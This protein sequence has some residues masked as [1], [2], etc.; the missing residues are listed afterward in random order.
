MQQSKIYK[1]IVTILIITSLWVTPVYAASGNT[2][3]AGKG[4]APLGIA[5]AIAYV[6]RRMS[7]G[8]WL[9]FYYFQL[10][11]SLILS[12]L[13]G[14][15]IIENLNPA[16]WEDRA[17]YTLFVISTIPAMLVKIVEVLFATRLLFKSQRNLKNV[18]SLRYVLLASVV[19]YAISLAID[20]FHFPDNVALSILG[21][22][23]AAIWTLYF[24]SSS[25][26]SSVLSNWSGSWDYQS[27][28]SSAE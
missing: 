14:G 13:L 1:K 4:L 26:V 2:G 27:F 23:F 6:T 18:K 24:F 19:M 7:I 12:L 28:K 20:Y 8:G 10:Y 21:L 15:L 3:T 17:L 9:F 5:L 11:G 25:R 22:V 16:G